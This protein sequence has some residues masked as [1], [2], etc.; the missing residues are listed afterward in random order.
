MT[1]KTANLN[2]E[3]SVLYIAMFTFYDGEFPTG[4]ELAPEFKHFFFSRSVSTYK[5]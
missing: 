4:K 5:I 1:Q 3:K 2:F